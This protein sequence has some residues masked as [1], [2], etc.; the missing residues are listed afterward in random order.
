MIKF[1]LTRKS[2]ALLNLKVCKNKALKYRN[3]NWQL[4]KRDKFTIILED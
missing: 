2:R 3:K 1:Q 4:E